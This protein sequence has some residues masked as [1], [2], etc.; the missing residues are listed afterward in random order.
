MIG[1]GTATLAAFIGAGGL[2]DPIVA[3]LALSDTRMVLSGAIPAAVLALLVDG[4]LALAEGEGLDHERREGGE[5]PAGARQRQEGQGSQQTQEHQPHAG[6]G[7]PLDL[8][9]VDN[10]HVVAVAAVENLADLYGLL[11]GCGC[12]GSEG[13]CP[14]VALPLAN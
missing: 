11:L 3:G 12:H 1:V 5:Q 13:I 6:L 4:L 7:E 9:E 2:G 10:G 8:V 14:V